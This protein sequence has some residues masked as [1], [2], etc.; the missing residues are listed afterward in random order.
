VSPLPFLL[1]LYRKDTKG[2]TLAETKEN[3]SFLAL[4]CFVLFCFCFVLF[5][6]FFCFF[7]GRAPEPPTS[8]RPKLGV[9]MDGSSSR[10][11]KD[12]AKVHHPDKDKDKDEEVEDE[13]EMSREEMLAQLRETRHLDVSKR[14]VRNLFTSR[15]PRVA[16]DSFSIDVGGAKLASKNLPPELAYMIN[17][18]MLSMAQNELTEL[19][20]S[21][22]TARSSF[23]IV[24]YLFKSIVIH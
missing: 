14:E 7:E 5:C 10:R 1:L 15:L 9:M 3:K 17:L 4:F 24:I 22:G 16:G 8:P 2:T 18:E 21:F 23:F 6:F 11:K 12:A 19:P 13:E 20:K